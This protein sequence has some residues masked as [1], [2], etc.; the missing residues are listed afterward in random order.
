MELAD[1]DRGLTA[2]DLTS[3]NVLFARRW[4]CLTFARGVRQ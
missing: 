1:L 4:D 3:I 2:G